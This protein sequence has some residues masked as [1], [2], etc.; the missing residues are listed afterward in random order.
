MISI[1]SADAT[2][3]LSGQQSLHQTA[4]RLRSL[5]VTRHFAL[6]AVLFLTIAFF[7]SACVLHDEDISAAD[8]LEDLKI[9]FTVTK[10]GDRRFTQLTLEILA[11]LV[12]ERAVCRAPKY[13]QFI[14][15]ERILR[16]FS[17]GPTGQATVGT[18]LF[19]G[20][21]AGPPTPIVLAS[22]PPAKLLSVP[23]SLAIWP[24]PPR[25]LF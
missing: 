14:A 24:V 12:R 3:K 20:Y 8:I 5:A 13:F 21:L 19:D 22:G 7:I 4:W 6:P 16:C 1:F 23:T 9:D 17:V 18:Y 2:A 11:N 10:P 25:P 15:H